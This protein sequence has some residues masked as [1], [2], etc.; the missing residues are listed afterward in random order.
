MV[1]KVKKGF[2][3]VQ[4]QIKLKAIDRDKPLALDVMDLDSED[5]EPV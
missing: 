2:A 4:A 5:K 1:L 3:T